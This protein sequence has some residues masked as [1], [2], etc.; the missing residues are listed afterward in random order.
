V[1]S[2]LTFAVLLLLDLLFAPRHSAAEV[3]SGS[4]L[5]AASP[6]LTAWLAWAMHTPWLGPGL[7]LAAILLLT[8][9]RTRKTPFRPVRHNVP[10][11]RLERYRGSPPR[12]HQ[13][14]EV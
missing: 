1:R 7:V 2:G 5:A 4:A 11:P 9:R 13:D 10:P 8:L 14:L 6:N 12:Q 3:P